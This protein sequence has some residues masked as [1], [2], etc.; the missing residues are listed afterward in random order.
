M[1]WLVT[2]FPLA[3]NMPRRSPTSTLVLGGAMK[4][5]EAVRS[6]GSA[7]LEG[8][9]LKVRIT[10]RSS[11]AAGTG[12]G[13]LVT[14]HH[15]WSRHRLVAQVSKALRV[16]R[17]ACQQ[18]QQ[19]GQRGVVRQAVSTQVHRPQAQP[20]APAKAQ[21]RQRFGR[22]GELGGHFEGRGRLVLRVVGVIHQGLVRVGVVVKAVC[23]GKARS[24]SSPPSG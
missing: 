16:A 1:A 10:S 3:S 11:L 14:Q 4:R 23:R 6:A 21:G 2:S 8:S 9:S 18:S 17:Q 5:S 15:R 20:V 19:V 24:G 22:G 12:D 7:S 13:A